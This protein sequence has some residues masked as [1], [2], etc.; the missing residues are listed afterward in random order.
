[1]ESFEL[2]IIRTGSHN[3]EIRAVLPNE[4]PAQTTIA[5]KP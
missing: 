5:Q 2:F 3:K 4:I 1:M